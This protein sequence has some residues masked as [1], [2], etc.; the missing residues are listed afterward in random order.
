[1]NVGDSLDFPKPR[2]CELENED[3]DR[4]FKVMVHL[5]LWGFLQL[6]FHEWLERFGLPALPGEEYLPG[7]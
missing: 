7:H 5:F 3:L 1:M 2:G 6:F 4:H